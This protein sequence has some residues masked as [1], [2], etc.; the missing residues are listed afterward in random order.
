MV[1]ARQSLQ[2][3][4]VIA[5]GWLTG[6]E[7]QGLVEYALMLLFIAVGLVGSLVF[8]QTSLSAEYAA[9][10]AVIPST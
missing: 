7:G 8:F 10:S 4:R 6:E 5:G 1:R 9:I 3:L 2:Q